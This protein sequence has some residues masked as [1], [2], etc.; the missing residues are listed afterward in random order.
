MW[1]YN[2]LND[3]IF[4]LALN[5]PHAV[6]SFEDDPHA[7]AMHDATR[8]IGTFKSVRIVD[9]RRDE[10]GNILLD[11]EGNEL[12][13]TRERG[14]PQGPWTGIE[15]WR[16]KFTFPDGVRFRVQAI[17][18]RAAFQGKAFL[19]LVGNTDDGHH[20]AEHVREWLAEV[21]AAAAA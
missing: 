14:L 4:M 11:E 5:L 8:K 17:Y 6:Q 3:D 20:D 10:D 15:A 19:I 16:G 13:V 1:K 9:Y 2:R 12:K 18:G 7:R 21:N